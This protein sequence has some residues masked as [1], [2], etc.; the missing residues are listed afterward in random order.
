[1]ALTP[2]TDGEGIPIPNVTC[3]CP[4]NTL[5]TP[6]DCFNMS[7]DGQITITNITNENNATCICIVTTDIGSGLCQT[8]QLIITG[9]CIISLLLP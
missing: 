8:I 2:Y 9:A 1:M 3:T 6:D 4:D 7:T 5:M